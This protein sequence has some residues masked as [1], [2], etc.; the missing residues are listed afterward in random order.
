MLWACI[1]PFVAAQG[2]T[3]F[4]RLGDVPPFGQ[5]DLTLEASVYG[6]ARACGSLAL[7]VAFALYFGAVDPDECCGCFAVPPFA[8]R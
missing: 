8:R 6:C 7:V 2:L 4:A 3:V 1:N 5:I